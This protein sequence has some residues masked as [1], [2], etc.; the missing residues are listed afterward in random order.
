MHPRCFENVPEWFASSNYCLFCPKLSFLQ[1]FSFYITVALPL[2]EEYQIL[3]YYTPL[4]VVSL[5]CRWITM[6]LKVDWSGRLPL[7]CVLRCLFFKRPLSIN[8]KNRLILF[9]LYCC[10]FLG[11]CFFFSSGFSLLCMMF[12]SIVLKINYPPREPHASTMQKKEPTNFVLVMVCKVTSN[13][14]RPWWV[15]Q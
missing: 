4:L 14:M 11:F 9:I 6:N 2:F 15:C 1:C 10:L 12:P 3:F 8:E 7:Y 5:H 13:V